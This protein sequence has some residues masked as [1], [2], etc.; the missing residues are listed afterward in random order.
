MY[1]T[2][3]WIRISIKLSR[4]RCLRYSNFTISKIVEDLNIHKERIAFLS[5]P[6]LYFSLDEEFR[7]QCYVFDFDKKWASDRGFVF[8]DFNRPEAVPDSLAHTFD[9]VVIDPPFITR[10]AWEKFAITAKLLLKPE[11]GNIKK[12]IY[13]FHTLLSDDCFLLFSSF[14]TKQF[15]ESPSNNHMREW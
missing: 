11:G 9:C 10:E 6:S 7:S 12:H 3:F 14:P 2:L 13:K 8:Y 4:I 5:T 15:R 1:S